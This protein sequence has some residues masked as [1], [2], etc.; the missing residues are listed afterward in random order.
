MTK[1]S[2]TLAAIAVISIPAM[3]YAADSPH[4]RSSIG[5]IFNEYPAQGSANPAVR[6]GESDPS[7]KPVTLARVVELLDEVGL[8]AT[9]EGESATLKMQHNRFSFPITISL[10]ADR[11]KV[12]LEMVL[13]ELEGQSA[14]ASERLL[15]LLAANMDFQPMFFS[16]D[17]KRKRIELVSGVAN[18]QVSG[19]SLQG[20]LGKMAAI[21]EST[22]SL[23]EISAAA[24][25]TTTTSTPS[26]QPAINNQAAPSQL[27]AQ[28]Q[29][30]ATSN[31]SFVGKWA[32]S[33]SQ[34]EAFAMQLNQDGSFVLVYVKD[35]KQSRST[36]K[37]TVGSNQLILTTTD[38]GK[39]SGQIS[40]FT[41]RSF[42]FTPP[43]TKAT[44]LTFQRAS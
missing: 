40:N 38:G 41:A 36:G 22:A 37:F 44:K 17:S 26:N 16:L 31:S 8:N 9:I 39:F 35:G 42:D 1:F 24:G 4:S 43:S 15:G 21:A 13:T 20:E 5:S 34:K 2:M 25:P 33:R 12:K 3:T 14:P 18:F 32:A 30:A 28:S 7:G 11:E 23:W 29:S 6:P 27:N 19:E 10:D